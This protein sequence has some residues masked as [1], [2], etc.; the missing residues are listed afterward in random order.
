MEEGK[1]KNG[2]K[3]KRRKKIKEKLKVGIFI[4]TI[5]AL[6]RKLPLHKN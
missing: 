5:S 6:L 1:E 2:R 4:A 3:E